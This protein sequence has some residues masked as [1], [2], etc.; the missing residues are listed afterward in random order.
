MDAGLDAAPTLTPHCLLGAPKS[1]KIEDVTS[2]TTW[3]SNATAQQQL[4]SSGKLHTVA[5]GGTAMVMTAGADGESLAA[6]LK[7]AWTQTEVGR[8]RFVRPA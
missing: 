1:N 3:D 8:V 7:F 6:L 5:N 4:R 2:L